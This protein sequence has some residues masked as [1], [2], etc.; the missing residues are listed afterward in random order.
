MIVLL[1][2][3][4]VWAKAR[5]KTDPQSLIARS[6]AAYYYPT[7]QGVTDMAVDVSVPKWA[8]T[9]LKD[10][11]ITFYYASANR[12]QFDIAN[13][14]AKFSDQRAQLIE[15]LAPYTN[16][17]IPTTAADSFKG[18]KLKSELGVSPVHR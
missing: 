16:F 12:Q 13:L 9:P 4:V 14:P 1:A 7:L 15:Q 6:D 10:V 8:D 18:F 5:E 11:K 17:L 2:S 3:A